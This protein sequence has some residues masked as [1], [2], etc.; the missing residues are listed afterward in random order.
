MSVGAAEGEADLAAV[1]GN[2][3]VGAG[4]MVGAADGAGEM[5][6][7][8]EIVGLLEIV[9]DALG[10]AVIVGS[11]VGLKVGCIPGRHSHLSPFAEPLQHSLT[12]HLSRLSSYA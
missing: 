9:G 12:A 4:E 6:G 8:L 7:A 1:G 10:T 3:A 2:E 11:P 5:V